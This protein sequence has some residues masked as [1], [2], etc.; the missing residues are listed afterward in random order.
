MSQIRVLAIP[1]DNHGVGKYRILDPYKFIGNNFSDEVHV[2]I[3]FTVED[4]DEIFLNYDIVV[5]HSFIHKKPVERNLERISW[6]K[7]KG[8]K[9]VMDIDDYWNVD[10][11]HPMFNQLKSSR[12]PESKVK[13]LKSVDYITCTTE[14]FAK[15]IKTKLGVKNIIVFPNAVDETEPQFKPNKIE[16]DRVRFGWLGGSSHLYDIELLK[17]GIDTTLNQYKDKTQFVLCGFDTRGTINEIDR[18]TGQIRKRPILPKETVWARYEEIFTSNY[19]SVSE[20]YKNHLLTYVQSDYQN[21]N[22]PY[23]RRWTQEINK[24][25]FNYNHFD[26][27]LAPLVESFFN[28]CKSELKIIEAG[29]HKK[30]IISSDVKPY[31]DILKSAV[32]EGKYNN[33]GNALLVSPRKNHKEWGKHMKRLIE[34]PNMIEDLG[35]RLYETVKDKYSLKNVSK[36]RVEF[37]KTLINKS[38]LVF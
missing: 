12:V 6:L 5:F 7:D 19:K 31:S 28:S 32:D 22:V 1:S 29:F 11:R 14:L 37:L 33:D 18:Q 13:L 15:E 23:V 21:Q 24:Y 2:D 9:V 35:N 30:A 25:A 8:I 3:I 10:Q 20:D 26:V 27:S 16:S 4:K 34:N 17:S 36:N 38:V